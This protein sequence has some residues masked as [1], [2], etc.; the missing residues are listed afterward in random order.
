MGKKIDKIMVKCRLCGKEYKQITHDHLCVRHNMTCDE[1]REMFPKENLAPNRNTNTKGFW[2]EDKG[3]YSYIKHPDRPK[4]T[5]SLCGKKLYRISDTHVLVKHQIDLD[6]YK[7]LFPNDKLF[8]TTDKERKLISKNHAD[9]TGKK[10][11]FYGKHHT[12]E[13][14]KKISKKN[15]EYFRRMGCK[16]DDV[17]YTREFRINRIKAFKRFGKICNMCGSEEHIVVHHIDYNK[18]NN[19]PLN[20]LPLCRVCHGKTNF[21]REYW[22]WYLK[23][24]DYTPG[25]EMKVMDYFNRHPEMV[26]EEELE[27]LEWDEN[28]MEDI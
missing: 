14:R 16:E 26:D 10:N 7:E 11:P 18:S 19:D 28:W 12:E 13:T 27:E 8:I 17:E 22:E 25:I 15:I 9:I 20:L 23:L 5:C 21:K 3:Y 24:Y 2:N 1:Y 6:T 4:V